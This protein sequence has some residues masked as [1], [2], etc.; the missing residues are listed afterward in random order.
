M[1][2]HTTPELARSRLS[3]VKAC[4]EHSIVLLRGG[5][6]DPRLVF[7][8]SDL[9]AWLEESGARHLDEIEEKL[10]LLAPERL[11]TP[12]IDDEE[13]L[14]EVSHW[15]SVPGVSAWIGGGPH[16][17][18]VLGALACGLRRGSATPELSARKVDLGGRESIVLR[19][20]FDRLEVDSG[21]RRCALEDPSGAARRWAAE[22]AFE[23]REAEFEDA[24]S[25]H[26]DALPSIAPRTP[27]TARRRPDGSWIFEH[28]ISP[29]WLCLWRPQDARLAREAF[30]H[31]GRAPFVVE[32][33]IVCA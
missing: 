32:R 28:P 8:R 17:W 19:S 15:R 23:W 25:F 9:S 29:A 21:E 33:S 10:I 27:L 4:S 13:F 18:E 14:H 5:S 22:M 1:S 31:D 6:T 2:T 24:I 26:A 30:F 20:A 7:V 3:L 16:P 11:E 12:A